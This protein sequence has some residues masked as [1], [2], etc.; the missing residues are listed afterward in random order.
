MFKIPP[1]GRGDERDFG[2]ELDAEDG[3]RLV[4][5]AGVRRVGGRRDGAEALGELAKLVTV[6]HPVSLSA[7]LQLR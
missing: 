4:G 2:V 6:A 3:L 1:P 5:D 7:Q